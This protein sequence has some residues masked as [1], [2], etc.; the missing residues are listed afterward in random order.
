[1]KTLRRL[2]SLVES[3]TWEDMPLIDDETGEMTMA[4]WIP[5]TERFMKRFVSLSVVAHM[6]MSLVRVTTTDK[7]I[8]DTWYPFEISKS[9]MYEII[10]MTQVNLKFK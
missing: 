10:L 4:G 9:P 7:M 5:R 1:M 3:F 6:T 2:F 8:Y